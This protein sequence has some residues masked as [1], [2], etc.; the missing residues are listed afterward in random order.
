MRRIM[1]RLLFAGLFFLIVGLVSECGGGG[2][3]ETTYTR[4]PTNT[5]RPRATATERSVVVKSTSGYQGGNPFG[6]PIGQVVDTINDEC[7]M[8]FAYDSSMQQFADFYIYDGF[9]FGLESDSVSS[10]GDLNIIGVIV[11]FSG[12]LIAEPNT[13]KAGRLAGCIEAV[14]DVPLSDA[15]GWS[16]DNLEKIVANGNSGYFESYQGFF[17]GG[18]YD[19]AND[20]V[21]VAVSQ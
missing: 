5:P 14:T 13:T 19:Y 8:N 1:S 2:E 20:Y 10:F 9:G 4:P 3:S 7:G 15:F 21:F 11:D 16:A 6:K 12:D 17:L 18:F